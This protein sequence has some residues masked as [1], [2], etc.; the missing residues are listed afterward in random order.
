MLIFGVIY[1]VNFI[2]QKV[3][4]NCTENCPQ[5]GSSRVRSKIFG[6]KKN[7]ELREKD[8]FL[9]LSDL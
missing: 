7:K 8:F 4:L 1:A 5:H 9:I 2:L 3:M 6:A